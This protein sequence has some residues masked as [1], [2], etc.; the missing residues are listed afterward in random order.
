MLTRLLLGLLIVATL[1]SV[2]AGSLED[3]RTLFA[4]GAFL[5]ASNLA[6]KLNSS[7]GFALAARALSEHASQQPVSRREALYVQCEQ[8]AR[9]ALELNARNPDGY[10][11]LGAATGHLG[12]LRGAGYAFVNGVA[13]QVKS[14][15]ERT[16]ELEPRHTLA[17]VALGRWHAEIVAR[18]VAFLFGADAVK[19]TTLFDRAVASDRAAFS[20]ASSTRGRCSCLDRERNRERGAGVLEEAVRLEPRDVL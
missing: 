15:F 2:R 19:V 14:N 10:F 3:A 1:S 20:H 7:A 12:N 9:R 8:F 4:S 5:E 16:L 18:G 13:G 11:E 6:S 17:L